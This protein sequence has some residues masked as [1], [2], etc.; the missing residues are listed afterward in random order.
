LSGFSTF[1]KNTTHIFVNKPHQSD[2]SERKIRSI[3][4]GEKLLQMDKRPV[5]LQADEIIAFSCVRNESL[6]L[7]YFLEYYRSLGVQRFIIVDNASGDDTVDLLL[8]QDDVHVFFTEESYAGSKCGVTWLNDLLSRY[9]TGHWTLTVDADELLVYPLCEKIDL[10]QLTRYLDSIGTQGLVSFLL[11]MYSDK[12]IQNTRYTAGTPFLDLC[13]Y[14]D[15]DS[16]HEKDENS[17]PV[18][19]GPRY[20]LFWEGRDREKPSPVLRKTPLVKWRD[21][22]EFEASTHVIANLR[23]AAITGALQHFK[24]FSD[25]Y[26]YAERETERKEHWDNAAQYSSYWEVLCENRDLSAMSEDSVRYR[27]STQLVELG[28]IKTT[29]EFQHFASLTALG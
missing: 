4:D 24:F 16:Y 21:G 9:G 23:M 19:G 8:S 10:H 7:P 6:R 26:E 25:F 27:N 2:N 15:R 14:F 13:S 5:K 17:V 1:R 20:R 12:A 22:L 3:A 18:R 29:I 28:L 11:D